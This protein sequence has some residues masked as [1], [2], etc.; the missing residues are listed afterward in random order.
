[1]NSINLKLKEFKQSGFSLIELMVSMVVGLLILAA[2]TSIF[3][4]MLNSN[5]DNLK[6]TRLNQ[7]LRAV[8]SLITRNLRRAGV[9]RESAVHSIAGTSN[10]FEVEGAGG[11]Q[12][13]Y[14]TSNQAG[15]ANKCIVF[16]YDEPPPDGIQGERDDPGELFGYRWDETEDAVEVR[17]AG[18]NCDAGGWGNVTDDSLIKITDLDF[19][20]SPLPLVP[21]GGESQV[22]RVTITLSGELI[23]DDKVFRTLVETINIRNN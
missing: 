1:M 6:S 17:Q 23:S 18:A 14:V 5:N 10:P 2:V 8:M 22:W 12:V 9:D 3:V 11:D 21:E 13:L 19:N 4:T 15:T 7:D 20:F 16:S